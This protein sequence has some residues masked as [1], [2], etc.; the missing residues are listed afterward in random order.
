MHL[1]DWENLLSPHLSNIELLSEMPLDRAAHTQ[2]EQ[3]LADFVQRHGLTEATRRLRQDYPAAFVAYLAFKAAFNEDRGFWDNV[4]RAIGLE[5]PQ[6]LF[7]PAHHW[8]QTFLEIIEAH[9][10]LRQFRGD[11]GHEYLTPIRLHGGIPAFS[12]PD[13]FQY[14]LLPSLEKAP[15]DGLEDA[16]ALHQLLNHY[17]AQLFVDDVVR[18]F[19]HHSGDAG[20]SFFSKCRRM[21]R[22]A[23]AGQPLP[24]PAELGLR[25]YVVQ[26]FET[27]QAR[28]TTPALRRRRPRLFFDP[29]APGFR[30]VLPPQPLNLEQAGQRL[31]ARLFDPESGETYATQPSLRPVR[32]GQDWFSPEVE[33]TL[34]EPLPSV[35]AGLFPAGQETPLYT[36]TLRLLPPPGYPPLVV[37]D[38]E[39]TRQVSLAPSLPARDLWLLCPADCELHAEPAARCIESLPP[40]A[41]PWQGWQASAW[42]LSETRLL[43]LLHEGQDVCPPIS[44]SRPLEPSLSPSSLPPHVLAVEE[45]PLYNAAPQVC[46]PLQ[47]PVSPA[48]E[49]D[50]WTLRLESRYA[51]RPQGKWEAKASDLPFVIEDGEARLSLAD[52]LGEQPIGTYHLSLEQRGRLVSELPFRV[53]AG[54]Q[55]SSLRPYYLPDANGAGEVS[56]QVHLPAGVS[57]Y[58]EDDET[59]L[60]PRP[61]GEGVG[62][63]VSPRAS[64]AN[65]RLELPAVP[66]AIRLPLRVAVP[67]LRWAL[68]LEK[69]AAIEWTHQPVAR[70]LAELLQANQP[71]LRVELPLMDSAKPL[72][73]L[74]LT[75]PGVDRPLQA[76]E[77]RS[78]SAQWL[79]FNLAGFSDTL[80]AHPEE[81]VF[82]FRLELLDA[83]QE[84]N[85]TLPVLRLSRP[86][87][88]QTCHMEATP[89]GGWTLHWYEPRPLRHRRLRVWSLWQPWLDPIEIPLPDD[90]PPSDSAPSPGWWMTPLPPEVSL[91]PAHYRAEFVAVA[92]YEKN[93]LSPLPPPHALTIEMLTPQARLTQLESVLP[94]KKPSL[95]FARHFEKL[96]VY[97]SLGWRDKVQEEIQGCLAHWRDASLI[98]L[99]ALVR[100]LGEY[101]SKENCRAFLMYLFREENLKRLEEERHPPEFVQRYLNNLRDAR[102]IHPESA[103]HVLKL[104][105]EPEVILRALQLLLTS[106]AEESRRVFWDLLAQG[107]LSETD[108]AALL[109]DS[110]DFARHLLQESPASPMRTRLLRALSRHMDLPEYLV[111]VGYSVLCDAG[112]GRIL[113][114]RGAQR[115]NL[116]FPTEETPTL[117]IEFLH[118][119][120]QTAELDLARNQLTLTGR[121]GVNRCACGRFAALGGKQTQAQWQEHRMFCGQTDIVPL[122][123][124]FSLSSSLIYRAAAPENPLDTRSPGG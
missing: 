91:P 53:C 58:A 89:D 52:W 27:Y 73:A 85:I 98:H 112:W 61:S 35:Q 29:Y 40:F 12:L 33:W 65:L 75:A 118:W 14:I 93:P 2:L 17:A 84:L 7:H 56:F 87:E 96:C 37:F 15:Y 115:E 80:R 107:R 1:Q 44:V 45:K 123:A 31:E 97:H 102:T 67:R 72:A 76:P 24:A 94:E 36:Y 106:S 79:E 5:S 4:A 111:K 81:S 39:K 117:V 59:T 6:P 42:N 68:M 32:Q 116:F 100:W 8:G 18:H 113:E 13:F 55:I 10:N 103:R 41:P 110:P 30:I 60:F 20:L 120:G 16:E 99:E 105:R 34:E 51:A 47:N 74:H 86:L 108:A 19:F 46:L 71:R 121:S 49:L 9:P 109:K 69:G 50:A 54:I 83:G 104:A 21:A 62:V 95:A 26:A 78:L 38:Y 28:Q 43:R 88:I 77:S 92:P 57:L 25:P 90:A 122:Q 48:A 114:I 82:E 101:E 124:S 66:E 23:G 11:W 63:R 64:Q 22:L 70:S 3:V 119:A